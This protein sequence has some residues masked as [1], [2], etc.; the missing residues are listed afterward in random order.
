MSKTG[1]A[2]FTAEASVYASARHYQARSVTF[3]SAGSVLPQLNYECTGSGSACTC[4]G[5][6][7]CL[8]LGTS[9]KCKGKVLSCTGDKCACY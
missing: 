8:D 1:L 6:F 5:A 2:G 3:G 4:R 7:D 9:G